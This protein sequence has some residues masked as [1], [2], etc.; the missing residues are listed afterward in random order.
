MCCATT[1]K[2]NDVG[3]TDDCKYET[4]EIGLSL[5]MDVI[6]VAGRRE[7]VKKDI[8]KFAEWKWKIK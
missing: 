3:E 8:R 7:E 2:V 1:A 4:M 6:S 5:Y